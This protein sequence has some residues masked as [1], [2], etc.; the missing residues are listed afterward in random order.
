MELMNV[1]FSQSALIKIL[2]YGIILFVALRAIH[3]TLSMPRIKKLVGFRFSRIFPFMEAII[4]ILFLIWASQQFFREKPFY[5]VFL[6]A[7]VVVVIIWASWF[8]VKDVIAGII[9]RSEDAYEINQLIEL[10]DL[11]GKVRKLGYRSLGI[12][13]ENGDYVKIPYSRIAGQLRILSDPHQ[14]IH[15]HRF[16]IT[17]PKTCSPDEATQQLRLLALNAPWFSPKKEPQVKTIGEDEKNYRFEVVVYSPGATYFS[18]IEN[19]FRTH[20]FAEKTIS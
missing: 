11:K 19:Y 8:A 15:S 6:A 17:I 20:I 13:S 9:L 2:L 18:K 12:E 4:W 16:T 1:E 10:N 5:N 14:T 7:A 3:R